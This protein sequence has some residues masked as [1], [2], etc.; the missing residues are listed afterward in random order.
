VN[1]IKYKKKQI[2][3]VCLGLVALIFLAAFQNTNSKENEKMPVQNYQLLP[4]FI[5]F[6]NSQRMLWV[7]LEKY[8][9]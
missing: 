2:I 3:S 6:M 1:L 4:L 8:H 7:R 5:P 9:Y